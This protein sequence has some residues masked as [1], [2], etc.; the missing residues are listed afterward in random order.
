MSN[1]D[2]TDNTNKS[3]NV[4]SINVKTNETKINEIKVNDMKFDP[5]IH[6]LCSKCL[7]YIVG[8]RYHDEYHVSWS[9]CD[10]TPPACI[11]KAYPDYKSKINAILKA[12]KSHN[13]NEYVKLLDKWI[14]LVINIQKDCDHKK[15]W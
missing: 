12:K 3:T 10:G 7:S 14:N 8:I 1:S 11:I 9:L 4:K 5:N 2:N 13:N 15:C 6:E